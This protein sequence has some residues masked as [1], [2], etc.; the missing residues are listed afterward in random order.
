M[1]LI[2]DWAVADSTALVNMNF[3][4]LQAATRTYFLLLLVLNSQ[5][6]IYLMV[7]LKEVLVVIDL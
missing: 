3:L 6:L 7:C 2:V 4:L 1:K 5:K